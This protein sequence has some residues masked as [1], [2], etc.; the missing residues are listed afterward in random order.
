ML[1]KKE[2]PRGRWI[3]AVALLGFAALNA[4]TAVLLYER[5]FRRRIEN[6]STEGDAAKRQANPDIWREAYDFDSP[7]GERL[8]GFF[9]GQQ[10]VRRARQP[11]KSAMPTAD[12]PP[13]KA[14]APTKPI[15]LILFAHGF[16]PGHTPYLNLIFH[17]VRQGFL[18]YAFDNTG[19]AAS[20]G[21]HVRGFAHSPLDLLA[22]AAAVRGHERGRGLPLLLIGHSWGAW[23][24]MAALP[25]LPEV[26]GAV[27]VSGPN[28]APSIL[29]WHVRNQIGPLAYLFKPW[30]AL[31]ERVRFGPIARRTGVAGAVSHADTPVLLVHAKDDGVV[32]L[33][34]SAAAK[35]AQ[36]L[37]SSQPPPNVAVETLILPSGGHLFYTTPD[38]GTQNAFFGRLEPEVLDRIVVFLKDAALKASRKGL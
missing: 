27:A 15:G 30:V 4:G 10:V 22:A 11:V 12:Q 14:R 36:A 20:D 17:L 2:K 33:A 21:A 32:P 6:P 37:N 34:V 1:F 23:S 19:I 7:E 9:Y 5:A 16:G 8:R 13:N 35:V 3:P 38:D 26:R 29:A 24:V 25:D 18:V 31:H 28:S